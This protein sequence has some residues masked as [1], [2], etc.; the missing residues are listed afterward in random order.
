MADESPSLAGLRIDRTAAPRRRI[1][2]GTLFFIAAALVAATVI[3]WWLSRPKPIAVRTVTVREISSTG[4]ATLLN[5]TGYV[6]ARR[7]ATVSSKITGKILEVLV[8]EGKRVELGEVL[9]RVDASNTQASVRLSEA[10]LSATRQSLAETDAN[11]ALAEVDFGRQRELAEK[12]IIS[13]ADLDR[14][15]S[16]ARALR[17]RRDRLLADIV[18]AER[19]VDVWK[20]QLDDT[21]IRAPFAG[22]VTSKNAQPGEMISPMSSGGFTR[23]GV[24]TLVDM[25]SLE[26]E[27]DVSESYIN[28][29]EPGQ[30]V[31]ATLDAYPDWK[32]PAHVIA[33]IPTADRQKATVKV[34]VG[35]DQLDPRILPDM[36]VKV[37][38]QGPAAAAGALSARSIVLPRTAVRSREGRELVFVVEKGRAAER[39]V[40]VTARNGEEITLSAGVSSG[41]RVVSEGPVDLV[42]GST[43]SEAKK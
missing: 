4:P 10:Q 23:T 16:V 9:A 33:I 26:I 20:Q 30:P 19:Q 38:F 12:K 2:P 22:I 15:E 35:F 7:E 28:R 42:D 24:C 39:A 1:A 13:T 29:V 17:G 34:R 11:L 32:I 8:E 41:E 37:A 3:V 18:V 6:T 43:V 27:I 5:A 25:S 40:T 14:A 31:S 21:V 36:G